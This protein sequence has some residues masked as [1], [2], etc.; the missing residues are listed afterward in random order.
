MKHR[1][2]LTGSGSTTSIFLSQPPAACRA[3]QNIRPNMLFSHSCTSPDFTHLGSDNGRAL[4]R[5]TSNVT[6][7]GAFD[8]EKGGT[9]GSNSTV[10]EG[11]SNEEYDLVVSDKLSTYPHQK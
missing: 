6:S 10:E 5:Y 4:S 3:N 11:V 2:K 1:Q 9:V 7:E 8:F